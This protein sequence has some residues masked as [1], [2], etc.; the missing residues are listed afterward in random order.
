MSNSNIAGSNQQRRR[1]RLTRLLSSPI[2]FLA[3]C[4][5]SKRHNYSNNLDESYVSITTTISTDS[6]ASCSSLA[7]SPTTVAGAGADLMDKGQLLSAPSSH[8]REKL[9]PEYLFDHVWY[10]NSTSL[11]NGHELRKRHTMCAATKLLVSHSPIL[12]DIT[13][14]GN[15]SFRPFLKVANQ[16]LFKLQVLNEAINWI[17]EIVWDLLHRTDTF[18]LPPSIE[19]IK[20]SVLQRHPSIQHDLIGPDKKRNC[21]NMSDFV[22]LLTQRLAVQQERFLEDL[23]CMHTSKTGNY[24]VCSTECLATHIYGEFFDFDRYDDAKDIRQ[25][26]LQYAALWRRVAEEIDLEGPHVADE[27]WSAAEIKFKVMKTRLRNSRLDE[28]DR[29]LQQVLDED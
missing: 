6:S 1:I 29:Y 4:H 17:D 13:N 2:R 7:P 8:Q 27:W 24:A 12:S 25:R 28:R 23:Y 26:Y 14:C 20:S 22:N 18:S 11:E 21:D 10:S 9:L 15:S 16:R 3:S 5:E 19:A